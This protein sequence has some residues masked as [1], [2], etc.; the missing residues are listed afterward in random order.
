M[1]GA[2][3]T[4]GAGVHLDNKILVSLETHALTAITAVTAQNSDNVINCDS[5]STENF[6]AQLNSI[7][8]EFEPAAIK[9][10]LILSQDQI[11]GAFEIQKKLGCPLVWDP[12]MASSS[13]SIFA[14]SK[15]I[16]A[17]IKKFAS[18]IA[19]I[20][21]NRL[22]AAS[23]TGMNIEN[24]ADI[25]DA[26]NKLLVQGIQNVY[27][28]GG[29]FS[30]S[31]DECW[32]Y[33]ASES[34]SMW[35]IG[36]RFKDSIQ[37]KDVRGSG[38][39]LSTAIAAGLANGYELRD[40]VVLARGVISSN[41]RDSYQHS[42]MNFQGNNSWPDHHLNLPRVSYAKDPGE[43]IAQFARCDDHRLGIYPVVDSA[44][45]LEK[46]LPLGIKTIQLRIKEDD[47]AVINYEIAAAVK[48][49]QQYKAKLFINDYW[50]LAIKHKAYGIHLGQEDIQTADLN[51]IAKSGL[52]LGVSTHSYWEVAA[53]IGINPSYIA[54]GPIF[55]TTSK[56]MPFSPQGVER[57][58]EWVKFFDGKWPLVAIGGID[59]DRA[60]AL[61]DTGI[62]SVAMI[63][64]ITQAENY[65]EATNALTQL[66]NGP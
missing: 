12:V 3:P 63:S 57:V 52:R 1:G 8:S 59:Y 13:G 36:K 35:V 31:G 58:R 45:W 11:D 55:E 28:K 34:G 61:V 44:D 10:G 47:T 40:A 30:E 53:A 9:L 38:C 16:Q 49:A 41:I 5:V 23:L 22:E 50:D 25:R 64:E 20:T 4:G 7:V 19:L 39:G 62:G 46:L 60:K 56:Q 6:I 66:W 21:P 33:F 27:L 18:N 65:V 42:K 48:I 29:H 32:D 43:S 2:D 37:E 24:T 54:L 14:E 17:A 26:A 15:L 51:A